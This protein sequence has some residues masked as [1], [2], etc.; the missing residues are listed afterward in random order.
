MDIQIPLIGILIL[1]CIGLWARVASL[2]DQVFLWR[3][4]WIIERFGVG[5]EGNK[6]D[7][8]VTFQYT[9]GVKCLIFDKSAD[10]LAGHGSPVRQWNNFMGR[11][12]F[13]VDCDLPEEKGVGLPENPER[14]KRAWIAAGPGLCRLPP[15]LHE[16][17]AI[18]QD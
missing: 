14:S 12:P 3:K 5:V 17:A 11:D 18:R 1:I 7:Y 15:E 8:F 16:K 6:G 9:N 4:R 10:R 2:R 13:S